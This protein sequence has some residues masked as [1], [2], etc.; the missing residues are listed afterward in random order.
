M[1]LPAGSKLYNQTNDSVTFM[2]SG[3]TNALPKLVIIKRKAGL[4]GSF[5]TYEI[6][7]VIGKTQADGSVKNDI[8]T[9]TRRSS[10][11]SVHG[12]ATTANTALR[13]IANSGGF[14]SDVGG[15]LLLPGAADV[16]P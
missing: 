5:S 3:H 9:Y 11:A 10:P 4:N 12:D 13:T 14:D 1:L 6:K 7:V 16:A 15:T 8:T 2:L